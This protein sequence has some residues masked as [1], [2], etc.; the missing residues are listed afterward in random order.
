MGHCAQRRVYIAMAERAKLS[1][2]LSLS[3]SLVIYGHV[4][5]YHQKVITSGVQFSAIT[6]NQRRG[7]ELN[8]PQIVQTTAF[9]INFVLMNC[10]MRSQGPQQGL[11]DYC[12]CC[13]SGSN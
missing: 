13:C 8:Q 4:H 12:R 9:S 6:T 1:I 7:D 11:L 3:L 10:S 5:A 2:S